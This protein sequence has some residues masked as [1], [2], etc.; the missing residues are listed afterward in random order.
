MDKGSSSAGSAKRYWA[1]ISYSHADGKEAEWLHRSLEAFKIPNPLI[2]T[3]SRNGVVPKRI[4]PV[5]RD[6]DELPTSADLGANLHEALRNSRYL[7]VLCSPKSAESL[8]VNAEV[9]FFKQAHGNANVLC[10]IVGGTPGGRGEGEEAECFCPALRHHIN[11]DGTAGEPSEPIAA[12][13]RGAKD[14]RL[15]AFLKIVAGIIGVDFDSL[16]QREKRRKIKRMVIVSVAAGLLALVGLVFYHR[17]DSVAKSQSEIASEVKKMREMKFR[18]FGELP[19]ER[20]QALASL[21][22]ESGVLDFEQDLARALSVERQRFE[23][24]HRRLVEFMKRRPALVGR[25]EALL[26]DLQPQ[27]GWADTARVCALFKLQDIAEMPDE[28]SIYF[29][30]ARFKMSPTSH[31]L[32]RLPPHTLQ[33][34]DS[35]AKALAIS[36]PFLDQIEQVRNVTQEISSILRLLPSDDV[37]GSTE[38]QPDRDARAEHVGNLKSAAWLLATDP[39]SDLRD[40]PKALAFAK[41]ALDL[42][43][44][45]DPETLD[46]LA[47]AHAAG[48]NFDAALHWQRLAVERGKNASPRTQEKFRERLRL[49]EGRDSYRR[50]NSYSATKDDVVLCLANAEGLDAWIVHQRDT[51]EALESLLAQFP[52]TPEERFV[53]DAEIQ[54][55]KDVQSR[56]EYKGNSQFNEMRQVYEQAKAEAVAPLGGVGYKPLPELN[57]WLNFVTF[58]ERIWRKPPD[59]A[60]RAGPPEH[61]DAIVMTGAPT[62]ECSVELFCISQF[63]FVQQGTRDLDARGIMSA[64]NFARAAA[65]FLGVHLP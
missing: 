18:A 11:P 7:I 28:L 53:V 41:K 32:A 14:G 64:R 20:A 38:V 5:F 30:D 3:E 25:V 62:R 40:F 17:L 39:D 51:H 1:F 46:V 61:T 12:D 13:L 47:A 33:D 54:R 44:G 2:G 50:A 23:K 65:K 6:R 48:G 15:R 57:E 27:G 24:Y 42:T 59:A 52:S 56:L 35:W 55:L 60:E 29:L 16:Y 45:K 63:V 10:L 36:G 21:I 37:I 22:E 19:E 43:G 49:Y 31:D 9:A 8:W 26:D 34:G 4:F 58:S